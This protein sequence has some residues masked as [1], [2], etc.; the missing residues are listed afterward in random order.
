MDKVAFGKIVLGAFVST[1]ASV[2]L[3]ISKEKLSNEIK[4]QITNKDE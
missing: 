4:S 1:A 3:T 2:V